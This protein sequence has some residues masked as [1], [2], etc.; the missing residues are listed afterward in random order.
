MTAQLNVDLCTPVDIAGAP[1]VQ[2]VKID[3][4]M[5]ICSRL[6]QRLATHSEHSDET[7]NV[8]ISALMGLVEHGAPLERLMLYEIA[9]CMNK[10]EIDNA[11]L[12]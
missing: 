12:I 2:Y 3:E 7:R 10:A 11:G 6:G 9:D 8:I 4:I 5:D 1:S